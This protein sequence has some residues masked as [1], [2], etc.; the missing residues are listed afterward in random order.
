MRSAFLVLLLLMSVVC[1]EADA[2][3]VIRGIG[4][5]KVIRSNEPPHTI[6]NDACVACHSVHRDP[7]AADV[8]PKLGE[9]IF[10]PDLPCLR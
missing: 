1:L 5:T 2:E 4:G 7:P 6:L 8:R 9:E 3:T 10:R